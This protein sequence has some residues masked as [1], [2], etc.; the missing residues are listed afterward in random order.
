[1]NTDRSAVVVG[2]DASRTATAAEVWALAE[3]RSR[4][5]PLR[6]V[7][8][9]SGARMYAAMSEFGN[10]SMTESTALRTAAEEMLAKAAT[11]LAAH[12]TD[13]EIS[14]HAC[15]DEPVA[16]LL[17]EARHASA[18]V[19][20]S[21]RLGSLNS[22]IVGSVG[23]ALCARAICPVVVVRSAAELAMANASVV[24]GVQM[25]ENCKNAIGYAFDYASRHALR[26]DAVLC[27]HPDLLADASR[28]PEQI[29]RADSELSEAL[30]GWREK[31]PDVDVHTMVR[32]AHAIDGLVA[33]S[34]DQHLL[35]VG[36]RG[37]G[38]VTGMLLGS[39]SQGV[40]H[41]ASCPI[42]VVPPASRG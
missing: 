30:A 29:Q 8:A 41:H 9:Y 3:A 4:K 20:G 12:G 35:V 42:V 5:V 14:T 38:A 34:H 16:V 26:L 36:T 2:Y 40:V 21:R 33:A 27:W 22:A 25:D 32:Q 17:A 28:H 6:L 13:V 31:Y 23:T 10:L 19:L 24:V 15:D 7:Y 11:R 1:M 18:V 39:V 37:R